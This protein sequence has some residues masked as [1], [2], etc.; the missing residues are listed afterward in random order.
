MNLSNVIH[1]VLDLIFPDHCLSCKTAGEIICLKCKNEINISPKEIDG[2]YSLFNYQTPVIKKLIHQLKYQGDKRVA[3]ILAPYIGDFLIENIAENN[4]IHPVNK[5]YYLIPIPL[6]K[7]KQR[8]R[9]FNQT[10]LI[11]KAL[12][13]KYPLLKVKDNILIRTKNNKP[14]VKCTREE[15]IKNVKDIFSTTQ[16]KI[17]PQAVYIILDDVTTTGSTIKEAYV[18]LK[19]VGV[20]KIISIAITRS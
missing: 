1:R 6:H 20:N 9:G 19:K 7:Q 15:R 4:L 11:A 8:Q 18:V 16:E 13:E 14:Q 10:N 2:I 12:A 17:N 5:E 3:Q